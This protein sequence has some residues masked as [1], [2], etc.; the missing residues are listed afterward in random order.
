MA[1][2]LSGCFAA[3]EGRA[4]ELD[5]AAQAARGAGDPDEAVRLYREA[6]RTWGECGRTDIQAA[7]LGNLA[8]I[9]RRLGELDLA[10]EAWEEALR[11]AKAR[12]DKGAVLRFLNNRGLVNSAWGRWPEALADY[13]EALGLARALDLKPLQAVLLNNLGAVHRQAGDTDRALARMNEALT[14]DES[15]GTG[16]DAGTRY[17]NLGAVYLER[18]ELAAALD[19][20]GKA[21]AAAR[22]RGQQDRIATRMN[23]LG[24]VELALGRP[25]IALDLY[26]QSLAIDEKAGARIEASAVLSN[27][28]AAEL[29]RGDLEA[30]E[31]ALLRAVDLK[32]AVRLTARDSARRDYLASQMDTYEWLVETNARQGRAVDALV[33]VELSRAKQLVD[34]LRTTQLGTSRRQVERAV[35]EALG[36]VRS[37]GAV[38]Y[39]ANVG[40]DRLVRF[41]IARGNVRMDRI[42]VARALDAVAEAVG[43]LPQRTGRPRTHKL[44]EPLLDRVVQRYRELLAT[45]DGGDDALRGRL[46]RA[47]FDLLVGDLRGPRNLL[48]VPGGVLSLVPFETLTAP[49]GRLLVE[50]YDVGYAHSLT[51][52][53]LVLDRPAPNGQLPLLAFGGAVYPEIGVAAGP[54]QIARRGLTD[55]DEAERLVRGRALSGR[56]LARWYRA[57][58]LRWPD[59]P[60]T[61]DE[62]EALARIV[63]GAQ[64]VVGRDVTEGKLKSLS[65]SGELLR[66]RALHFA[67]HGIAVPAIPELSALVL[68]QE[69]RLEPSDDDYVTV[70]EV[71][72]LRLGAERVVLSACESGLG[73]LFRGEGLVGLTQA[74]LVAGA[75]SATVSLWQVGDAATMALMAAAYR[76]AQGQTP[77]V[78][79]L[80]EAKRALA[81]GLLGDGQWR[82]PGWWAA[83]VHFGADHVLGPQTVRA[84]GAPA[85]RPRAGL[86]GMQGRAPGPNPK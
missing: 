75:R 51:V 20:L 3:W 28:G 42:D 80:A 41:V 74:F 4:A 60:G 5:R 24:T 56:D 53:K 2:G 69:P 30:A 45:A 12:G 44:T 64:V 58:G 1:Y 31:A 22:D 50:T 52:A 66:Y 19:A 71:A 83:F 65:E 76:R 11:I 23:N 35:T 10:A 54:G 57:V 85:R 6:A 55:A 39:F 8:A 70:P 63:P 17:G 25:E 43:P 29:E 79:A 73:R 59:L 84:P 32:E 40:W 34:Q 61:R 81:G 27:I 48:V 16:G 9:H 14:L 36:R 67:T 33:T 7:T 21:L 47:L 49:D 38:L 18:G 46:S 26:R 78:R 82:H 86:L 77:W 68:S 72:R 62:V 37:D 13:E 15:L